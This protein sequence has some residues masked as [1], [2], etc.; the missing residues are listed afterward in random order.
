MRWKG[1]REIFR[2]MKTKLFSRPQIIKL[3]RLLFMKYRPSEIA[4]ILDI[5]VNTIYR[6]YLPYGCPHERDQ[7]GNIWIIGTK[8]R[9][10]AQEVIDERKRKSKI[11]MDDNQGY[12]LKC[13]QR[14]LMIDPK[15]IYSGGNREIIQS[16]CPICGTNINRARGID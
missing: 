15:V 3:S 9:E 13:N 1:S 6:N 16:I 8:F 7:N 14:V 5:N 10:W 2:N 4:P 11:P 12:C